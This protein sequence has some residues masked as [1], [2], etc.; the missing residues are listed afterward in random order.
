MK[1]WLIVK[2]QDIMSTRC[3]QKGG[4]PQLCGANAAHGRDVDTNEGESGA[5][6]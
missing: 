2:N 1:W 4:T 3:V 5:S 6:K